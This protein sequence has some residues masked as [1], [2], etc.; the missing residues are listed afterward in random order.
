MTQSPQ[1][2][3]SPFLFLLPLLVVGFVVC[4]CWVLFFLLLSLL[5]CFFVGGHLDNPGL[6]HSN[7]DVIELNW[8][9]PSSNKS[10]QTR[11]ANMCTQLH[12]RMHTLPMVEAEKVI[13][14]RMMTVNRRWRPFS[15][16]S[17]SFPFMSG[18]AF[19]GISGKVRRRQV[20]TLLFLTE[21]ETQVA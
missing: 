1:Q 19:W 11:M 18:L 15:A 3:Y 9:D 20:L 12:S 21:A 6:P 17:V 5:F 14:L 13:P 7:T 4:H 10:K 8:C 16:W 2:F